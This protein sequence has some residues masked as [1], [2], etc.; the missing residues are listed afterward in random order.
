VEAQQEALLK[1]ADERVLFQSPSLIIAN[2]IG[3]RI[4]RFGFSVKPK[5][6][7][8]GAAPRTPP[9]F[10]CSPKRSRQEKGVSLRLA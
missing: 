7:T 8:A 6:K 10:F 4:A 2:Y 1:A 5:S 3:G 9:D